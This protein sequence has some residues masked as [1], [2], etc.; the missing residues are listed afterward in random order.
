M[1]VGQDDEEARS[2]QQGRFS[3]AR[4][5]AVVIAV[6]LAAASCAAPG[7]GTS[8]PGTPRP[9]R[10]PGA[11]TTTLASRPSTTDPDHPGTTVPAAAATWRLVIEPDEGMEPIYSLMSSAR[12][13]LDMT[14]YELA[15]PRAIDILEGDAAR[16]VVVRV[17]LD[18]D[19]A[20]AS[21]NAAAEAGLASHGVQVHWAP[22][23]TIFHQKTFTL[24]DHTSVVMTLNLTS[25][26]YASTR[27]F[28]VITTDDADVAAIEEGFDSDW[29]T[30]G[31]PQPGSPGVNLVWSP[32]AGPPILALIAS[33]RHSLLVESE[34]M[35]DS[36]VITAL[37][38]AARRGVDVEVVMTYSSSW[39]TA[40]D[41]L[42]AAGVKVNT[43]AS[44]AALYIHAKV[45]VADGSRAF[46]GSQNF[47]ESSLDDNRELGIITGDPALV[48]PLAKTVASDFKG[49]TP[50]S[51][52]SAPP[53]TK[54]PA[55]G[56]WC[57]A[58]AAPANDG[59]SGDYDVY[60]HSDQPDEKATASDAGDTYSYDTDASGYAVI[61]LWNTSPGE[62]ISVAI[63]GAMCST[64]A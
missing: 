14:M 57:H 45:V 10:A 41:D 4:R 40:L 63:G 38:A 51:A 6:A 21:V 32:G 2:P 3:P 54:P 1:Q 26:Y 17:I 25:Q 19:Y 49:G 53:S 47:S 46:V 7:T 44:D 15:D 31:P 55:S 29:V 58:N 61:Y 39:A 56:A 28:A 50:L 5:C 48:T 16:G 9:T 43:Y 20:G 13:Q 18:R 27:D 52:G 8:T 34:E 59:Y 37:E 11:A 22:A 12:H 62:T 36:A 24:D 35:D 23:S 33:A 30:G 60:V 42:A 64:T